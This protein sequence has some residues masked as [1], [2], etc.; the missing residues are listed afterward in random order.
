MMPF[1]RIPTWVFDSGAFAKLSASA[2]A[3]LPVLGRCLE[4]KADSG[5]VSIDRLCELSGLKKSA[6][7]RALG[8]LS[9]AGIIFRQHGKKGYEFRESGK[10]IPPS[11]KT[12]S[13]QPESN[14][15]QA[16]SFSTQPENHPYRPRTTSQEPLSKKRERE[17]D[18]NEQGNQTEQPD[19]DRAARNAQTAA[20]LERGKPAAEFDP[21]V[22]SRYWHAQ[23]SNGAAPVKL[24]AKIPS[25][26]GDLTAIE[27]GRKILSEI[28]W[29][30]V[31][32]QGNLGATRLGELAFAL[33]RSGDEDPVATIGERMHARVTLERKSKDGDLSFL[34]KVT[35]WI[36]EEFC[37][38]LAGVSA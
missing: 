7:Y 8:E 11:R 1:A 2:K 38:V 29:P 3:V 25:G 9:E 17:I 26:Y 5:F 14:S 37:N 19:Q 24:P 16:E 27:A 20:D 4:S 12:D 21:T 34:P 35:N 36:E 33:L 18:Q 22:S 15:T 10:Q 13:T 23:R 6:A 30:E 28:G 32:R 31:R